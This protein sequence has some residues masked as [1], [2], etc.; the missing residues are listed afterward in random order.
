MAQT[1]G[2]IA[3]RDVRTQLLGTGF[4]ADIVIPEGAW[5]ISGTL[6]DTSVNFVIQD[7]ADSTNEAIPAGGSWIEGSGDHPLNADLTI[8]ALGSSAANLVVRFYT[9]P[10]RP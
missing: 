1:L 2:G 4:G 5:G 9:Y 3:E 10:K 7:Q 6:D 8:K